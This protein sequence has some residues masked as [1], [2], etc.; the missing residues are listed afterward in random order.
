[1]KP[2]AP[3]R[4]AL[5]AAGRATAGLRETPDRGRHERILLRVGARPAANGLPFVR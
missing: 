4:R 2:E 5:R 3:T 1:M